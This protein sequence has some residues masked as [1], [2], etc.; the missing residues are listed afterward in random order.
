MG[1]YRRSTQT[2]TICDCPTA[3]YFHS[4]R[5]TPTRGHSRR[6]SRQGGGGEWEGVWV[7]TF[8]VQQME[9]KRSL[10]VGNRLRAER[11]CGDADFKLISS[12]PYAP[13]NT[14]TPLLTVCI[15]VISLVL[16]SWFFFVVR[17]LNEYIRV[18]I[19]SKNSASH[20]IQ[21]LHVNGDVRRSLPVSTI[22]QRLATPGSLGSVSC[23]SA[24]W[25]QVVAWRRQ[26]NVTVTQ[27]KA[28]DRLNA[29]GFYKRAYINYFLIQSIMIVRF[30][31]CSSE[32]RPAYNRILLH[33]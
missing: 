6:P 14:P 18:H 13:S 3:A 20:R 2:Y 4:D 19:A 21:L 32:L 27:F 29:I 17:Q 33:L 16:Y 26:R 24:P 22:P 5:P 7:K 9:I 8:C 1:G 11:S 30:P 31:I 10:I 23:G 15:P 25:R 12:T 28:K